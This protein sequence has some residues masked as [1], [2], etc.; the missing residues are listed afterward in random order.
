MTTDYTTGSSVW[1]NITYKRTATSVVVTISSDGSYPEFPSSRNYIVRLVNN[2]P[3]SAARVNGKALR[4]SR[5]GGSNTHRSEEHGYRMSEG[6]V[7]LCVL[8][9]RKLRGW[10]V[11]IRA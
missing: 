3:L 8:W 1:T 11:R 9:N 2:N 4:S 7:R 5:F 6:T 10:A